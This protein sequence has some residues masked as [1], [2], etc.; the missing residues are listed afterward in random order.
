M[1]KVKLDSKRQTNHKT[2]QQTRHIYLILS[3]L[4]SDHS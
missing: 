2:K 3:T 1:N 4:Q